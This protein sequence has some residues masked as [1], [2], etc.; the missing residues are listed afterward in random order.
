MPVGHADCLR[1]G[2]IRNGES[3]G[4]NPKAEE[5]ESLQHQGRYLGYLNRNGLPNRSGRCDP[6]CRAGALKVK[7]QR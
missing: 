7:M 2:G 4:R 3:K 1:A 6:D 5:A